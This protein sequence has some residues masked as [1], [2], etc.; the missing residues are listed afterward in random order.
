MY[1]HFCRHDGGAYGDACV[2]DVVY[3]NFFHF[4]RGHGCGGG[5]GGG[6]DG[7]CGG[8]YDA[9]VFPLV[10]QRVLPQ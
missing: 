5:G 2:Y 7:A 6:G 9:D 4:F 3:L 1:L 8:A 10:A